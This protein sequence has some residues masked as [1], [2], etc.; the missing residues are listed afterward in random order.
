MPPIEFPHGH[1][2]SPEDLEMIRRQVE[3]F[4]VI[5]AVDDEIR[6][7]RPHARRYLRRRAAFMAHKKAL[8]LLNTVFEGDRATSKQRMPCA[9]S[10][11]R[12]PLR[13]CC[14]PRE[15]FLIAPEPRMY[16]PPTVRL[17][18]MGRHLAM[19][20]H[21]AIARQ[22]TTAGHRPTVLLPLMARHLAIARQTSMA[23]HRP[24]IRLP[25]TR[26]HQP[27]AMTGQTTMVRQLIT[28]RLRGRRTQFR[29]P[30]R[31]AATRYAPRRVIA[32]GDAVLG[33]A[34]GGGCVI[35][36]SL[37]QSTM[38]DPTAVS[39]IAAMVRH[40]VQATTDLIERN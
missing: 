36:R 27:T 34:D 12:L 25:V 8:E 39:L 40:R 24:T 16:L 4:E 30:F 6:G 19:G 11:L 37:R 14:S 20:R 26:R 9:T 31:R 15:L 17:L 5:G 22:T 21:P 29:M 32:S 10:S 18:S 28:V 1:P 3:E 13:Q 7:A 38:R 2:L 33:A 35:Q 23:R